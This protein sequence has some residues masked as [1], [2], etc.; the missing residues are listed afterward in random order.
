LKR[1]IMNTITDETAKT[2]MA[3]QPRAISLQYNP[4]TKISL[5]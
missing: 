1:R 5:P 3:F 4:D 2:A